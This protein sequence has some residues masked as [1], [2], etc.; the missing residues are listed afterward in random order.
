MP[1]GTTIQ[2]LGQEVQQA[3]TRALL[4]HLVFEH[5]TLCDTERVGK[6]GLGKGSVVQAVFVDSLNAEFKYVDQLRKAYGQSYSIQVRPCDRHSFQQFWE[7]AEGSNDRGLPHRPSDLGEV[8][9][10]EVLS[11]LQDYNYTRAL[12][13]KPE[14][15]MCLRNLVGASGCY[16]IAAAQMFTIQETAAYFDMFKDHKHI[17]ANGHHM[18]L[19]HCHIFDFS[20]GS[21]SS[22]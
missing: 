15:A 12:D 5:R 20:G 4:S 9:A 16:G 10:S 8:T 3:I 17:W 19:T 7:S 18:W 22:D 11:M 6:I 1:L 14:E 13:K 2:Q 21:S